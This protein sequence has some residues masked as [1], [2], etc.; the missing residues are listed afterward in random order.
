MDEGKGGSALMGASMHGY[1]EGEM[2]LTPP[3]RR[4]GTTSVWRQADHPL[5]M[6]L[7]NMSRFRGQFF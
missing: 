5:D 3:R 2:I 6:V 7:S 1:G 4:S